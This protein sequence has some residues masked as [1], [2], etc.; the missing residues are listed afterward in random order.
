MFLEKAKLEDYERV[1]SMCDNVYLGFDYLP[2]VFDCWLAEDE[3]LRRNLVMKRR[4][5]NLVIGFQSFCL[6]V[7]GTEINF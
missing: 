2:G 6:Q 7:R 3:T 4:S 5:D 1:M